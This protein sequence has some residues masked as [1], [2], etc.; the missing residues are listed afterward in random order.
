[1]RED[2]GAIYVIWLREVLKFWRDKS[3]IITSLIQPAVWLFIMGKGLGSS[4]RGPGNI[5]YVE[6][7]FP[8][9]I[10]MTVLFTSVFSAVSIIWDR[11]FGFLKEIL[12]AP[13]SRSS[14]VIGKALAGSTTAMLQGS[15]VL[16]FAPLVGVQLSIPVILKSLAVMFLLSLALTSCGIAGAARMESFHGF[17]LIMNFFVMPMY[18]LSG[19]VFPVSGLPA[20]MKLVAVGNPMAYGVDALKHIILG[21]QEFS[22]VRDITVILSV[23][24]VAMGIAVL[25]FKGEG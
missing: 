22:L 3:R 19:A 4:F 2:L 5:G 8:G 15:L 18:F 7:M 1:M 14:V 12:V 10:G 24:V 11:E 20:W 16:V 21:I 9:V 13:I 23:T 25:V 6:F 17:Q